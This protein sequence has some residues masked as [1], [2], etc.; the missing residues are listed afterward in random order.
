MQQ[1][2]P[3]AVGHY[4][5]QLTKIIVNG[6]DHG[7]VIVGGQ[8]PRTNRAE[9]HGRNG[10]WVAMPSLPVALSSAQIVWNPDTLDLFVFGGYRA[11]GMII[12]IYYSLSPLQFFRGINL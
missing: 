7:I 8:K 3:L 6:E 9:Y 5:S 11:S 2:D 4:S 1:A 12:I 10:K